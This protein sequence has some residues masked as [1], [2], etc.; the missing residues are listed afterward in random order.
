MGVRY[1]PENRVPPVA[2]KGKRPAGGG[3]RI[4]RYSEP[5]AGF[6]RR[7]MR[8]IFRPPVI[9]ALV[10]LS[11]VTIGILGYYWWVFSAR[12][13]NLLNGEVY[14]RTAGI[15]A[16]P[17][18]LRVGENLSVEELVASGREF[19]IRVDRPEIA[20]AVAAR[21]GVEAQTEDHTIRLAGPQDET[22]RL[23][24]LLVHEGIQVYGA[25]PRQQTLEEMFL[26]VTGG[27][28]V[29]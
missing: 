9:I 15:Y 4:V 16:A 13:D 29:Q 19:E 21:H 26:D 18:E 2:K 14:T 11:T 25:Q 12:I 20:A 5:E 23:I 28:T 1:P 24:A 22:A 3:S 17:R 8:R 10:F 7:W 6:F 27:E